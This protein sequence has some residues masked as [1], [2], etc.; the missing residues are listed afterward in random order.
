MHVH[1]QVQQ[2]KEELPHHRGCRHETS[3][4]EVTSDGDN[5]LC[6]D[7]QSGCACHP[8]YLELAMRLVRRSSGRGCPVW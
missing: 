6:T 5:R 8:I 1:R 4:E 3:K 7:V 2:P